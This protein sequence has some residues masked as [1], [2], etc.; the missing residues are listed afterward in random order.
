MLKEGTRSR[1]LELIKMV[2]VEDK[3]VTRSIDVGSITNKTIECL[4]N[5][6]QLLHEDDKYSLDKKLNNIVKHNTGAK[7]NGIAKKHRPQK[8]DVV[9]GSNDDDG[10][11]SPGPNDKSRT[12]KLIK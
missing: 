12:E 11:S 1:I 3:R 4:L 8:I 9:D 7:P 5:Y 10:R 2:K 6:L